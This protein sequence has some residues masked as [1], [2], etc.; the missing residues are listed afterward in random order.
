MINW[1]ILLGLLWASSALACDTTGKPLI[2]LDKDAPRVEVF[3]E[4]MKLAQPFSVQIKV[5][6]HVD[7]I[8]LDVDAIMPAHQHGLNYTP[9]IVDVGDGVYRV[10][11]ML[12]HMPGIWEIRVNLTQETGVI[13]YTRTVTL[14]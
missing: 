10:D 11:G 3:L 8:K 5:C 7:V 9:T 1:A 12:F 13:R 14:R 6:D 4:D 2:S